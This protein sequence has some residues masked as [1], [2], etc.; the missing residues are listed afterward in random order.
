V[1]IQGTTSVE[2]STTG[3]SVVFSHQ[4]PWKSPNSGVHSPALCT[5]GTAQKVLCSTIS[6]EIT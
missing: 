5:T 2:I 3:S 6:P 4:W 1:S